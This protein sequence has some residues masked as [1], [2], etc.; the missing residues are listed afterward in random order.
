MKALALMPLVAIC[1]VFG[2]AIFA[3]LALGPPALLAWGLVAFVGCD[4]GLAIL[5]AIAVGVLWTILLTY[6]FN[7]NVKEHAP[8]SAGASVDHGVEGET[9]EDHVNR[10]ADRGCCVSSCSASEIHFGL[11]WDR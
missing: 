8:L 1:I 7:M 9:R 5:L 2:A 4:P 6:L 10:A 3:I 11:D